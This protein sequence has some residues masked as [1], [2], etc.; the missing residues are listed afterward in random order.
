MSALEISPLMGWVLDTF[1][2]TGAL[3]ALV[4]LVRR[5]VARHFGPQLAYA[6]WLLPLLRLVLPPI[7][8]PAWMAP[9]A[10][11]AAPA[12]AAEPLV[13]VF[14]PAAQ[15]AASAPAGMEVADLLLPLWLGGALVFLGWRVREYFRMRDTLLAGAVPVGEAGNVRLVET[16]A[17]ASPVAFGIF[18][19][20]VALPPAFMALHDRA[21]RDMAIAHELAHHKGHDLLANIAAQP[22]LALHWFNPLAWWGWRAMR[23][24]QEAA[25]DA[26]VVAGR[27]RGERAVYAQVI[28]GFAAGG[29]LPLAAPMAGTMACPMLGEKSIIHRLRSLTMTDVSSRR[30]RFGVAALATTALALP[31][32]A[33]ITYAQSEPP[34][35]G[36][37]EE[38]SET[39]DADGNRQ[40]R[41]IRW[42]GERPAEGEDGAQADGGHE[43]HMEMHVIRLDGEGAA[44]EGEHRVIR[45]RVHGA[46]GMSEAEMQAMMEEIHREL[47]GIDGE[48]QREVRM[49]MAEAR[50][51]MAEAGE[52]RRII[53]RQGGPGAAT[54][55]GECS[56]DQPVVRL[57]L[58]DGRRMV[59]VCQTAVHEQAAAGLRAALEEIASDPDMPEGVR[60]R[61]LRELQ[62]QIERMEGQA[63]SWQAQPGKV[64]AV[65]LLADAPA[66]AVAMR[67]TGR[68]VRPAAAPRAV[69]VRF[70][71]P[72]APPAPVVPVAPRAPAAPGNG[73]A[74]TR[75]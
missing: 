13:F 14:D 7:T 35:D 3:I 70:Q 31:L 36:V 9:A 44:G 74:A 61:V 52:Q 40:V 54:M 4:L 73:Q 64:E 11:A 30:R 26:R 56:D 68:V 67:W 45:R 15:P 37:Q 34:Q 22:L 43:R 62:Q 47:E 50:A 24:D 57:E 20:V 12:G 75:V 49:A 5:P 42:V 60:E 21:A 48:V 39:V 10:P 59:M 29:H 6:L 16:P 55:E 63:V 46:E 23:R 65:A 8:L 51:A 33:S 38:R 41:V 32:T 28:A 18:D 71:M 1:T 2:Y 19:K 58:A 17:V 25:C 72:V 27:S 66:G 53:M 69:S